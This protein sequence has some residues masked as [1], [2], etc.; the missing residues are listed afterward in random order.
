MPATSSDKQLYLYF[1]GRIL[2]HMGIQTYQSP[3]SSI[4]E[5]VANAW[6]ADAEKVEITLP[7]ELGDEAQIVI[8]DDGLGMTFDECQAKYLNVGFNRRGDD[9]EAK[10]SKKNRPVLGRKGIGKFAGFGIA[11]KMTVETTSEENGEKTVF[12]LDISELIGDEYIDTNAKPI[13]LFDYQGPDSSRIKNHGTKIV[14][15]SLKLGRP[16]PVSEFAKSMAR[17]YLL[18]RQQVG[19]EVLVNGQPLP[20]GIDLE[21]VEFQF[22]ADYRESEKPAELAD[23]DSQGW[24]LEAVAPGREILWR[25]F[26]HKDTIDEEELRGISVFA[27]GKLA[28][29]PFLFNLTG[30]LGGQHG[31]EYL[32]GQVQADY[33]DK[34]PY[35]LAATERQRINW[36]DTESEALLEWGQNRVK[37]LL[38]IWRDRRGEERAKKIDERLSGFSA[39][40]GRLERHEAETIQKAVRKLAQVPTLSDTQFEE[41][42]EAILTAWEQ[43][44]L[45]D[46]I[47]DIS[48][49]DELTEERLLRILAEAQVITALNT[50]EAIKTKLLT[51][52]H[53]KQ[54]IENQELE[55]AVRDYIAKNPWLIA[56]QWETF[57][58]ESAVRTVAQEAAGDVGF[59]DSNY[60][61]RVDLVLSSGEHLLVLEFMRPGL[62]I[63]WDHR[64]RF[65]RY[66]QIIRAWVD[67]NT[68]GR[69][70]RV[71]GYLIADQR[72]NDPALLR[73]I[74]KMRLDEMFVL[75]W[76]GLFQQ[77]ESD[78]SEYL[79]IL[80]SRAP[81]DQRLQFL[82]EE[83]E[84]ISE[85]EISLQ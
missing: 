68:G 75:D 23:V 40:I 74:T 37:R 67:G 21:K 22:P 12:G 70:R 15:S 26:F 18:H 52:A 10:S 55:A 57:K 44:R 82:L 7:S 53:L 6:D 20:E 83:E 17:R 81:E 62:K 39:R 80:A 42:G 11:V 30:G 73:T 4:A 84:G 24:G 38:R 78:W 46:L 56:P 41:L 64:D 16:P 61:G 1:H 19:F 9:P 60:A 45:R 58:V 14:L 79:A 28:Q 77:A 72:N 65:E 5:L 85:E 2:E 32:S 8:K 63:D 59:T 33:L 49:V 71:S 76:Q 35:D 50:A 47:T 29:A 31:V 66:I 25:V 3:V 13:E 34:L 43:G 54:R 48:G 69:F 27:K 51:V 36:G